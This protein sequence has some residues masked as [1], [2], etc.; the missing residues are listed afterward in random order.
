LAK[1]I[2]ALQSAA[3]QAGIASGLLCGLFI[4]HRLAGFGGFCRGLLGGGLPWFGGFVNNL[5]TLFSI[6]LPTLP[7]ECAAR[8][9]GGSLRWCRFAV[10]LEVVTAS[11]WTVCFTVVR[12]IVGKCTFFL[13]VNAISL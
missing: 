7:S 3:G 12:W 2:R 4:G 11:G 9:V 13:P 1:P 10:L 6:R 8:C 5:P